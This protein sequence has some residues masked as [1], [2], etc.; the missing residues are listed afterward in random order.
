[1]TSVVMRYT[2]SPQQ[3]GK[4]SLFYNNDI[5]QKCFM[6]HLRILLDEI[7]KNKSIWEI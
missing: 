6:W 1:M 4:M 2:F 5:K 7:A 3:T